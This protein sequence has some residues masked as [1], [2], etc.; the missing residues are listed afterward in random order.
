MR[1][2]KNVLENKE[3]YSLKLESKDSTLKIIHDTQIEW[4]TEFYLYFKKEDLKIYYK[5]N[6]SRYWHGKNQL[7]IITTDNKNPIL[8]QVIKLVKKEFP[9]C[10]FKIRKTKNETNEPNK[11]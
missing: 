3:L 1:S 8:K 10:K 11:D 9:S 7:D 6:D 4:G 2:L 5:I